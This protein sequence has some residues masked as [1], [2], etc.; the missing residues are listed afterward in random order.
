[1]DTHDLSTLGLDPPA[2]RIVGDYLAAL[3]SHLP[4]G[5]RTRADILTEIA[6]GLACDIEVRTAR[7]E[8]AQAAATAAVAEIG[9]PRTLA[10]AFA[11][12]LGPVAARRL[13]VG[14]VVTGPLVGLIWVTAYTVGGSDWPSRIVGVLSAVPLYLPIMAVTVPAATIAANGFGRY[15]QR[16]VLPP[17][18]VT[19]AA[20]VAA[21]GCVAGDL[22]LLTTAAVNHPTGLHTPTIFALAAAASGVRLSAATW[23][24][25]RILRLRAAVS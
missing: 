10:M 13:G 22:S 9:D 3:A 19:G 17:R 24:A 16:R 7:G 14:L 6:D 25:H 4:A 18:V 20:L 15:G 23:A 2:A 21:I 1:V 5:R 8:P 12:Q 11:G